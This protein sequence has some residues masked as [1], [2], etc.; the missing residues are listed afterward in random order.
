MF[1]LS[2]LYNFLLFAQK[3]NYIFNNQS[4]KIN[5]LC[6]TDFGHSFYGALNSF[7]PLL[8]IFKVP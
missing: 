6:S 4:S 1:L 2:K 7:E 3:N 5:V 8:N